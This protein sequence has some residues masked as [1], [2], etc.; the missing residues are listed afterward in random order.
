MKL[1]NKIFAGTTL[2][3]AAL[4]SQ[5][6]I[7]QPASG[8]G[9]LMVVLYTGGNSNSFVV[10]LGVTIGSFDTTINQSFNLSTSPYYATFLSNNGGVSPVGFAVLGGDQSGLNTV[11]GAKNFFFTSAAN[12]TPSAP[13][14]LTLA[15]RLGALDSFQQALNSNSGP[16]TPTF[17]G[18]HD[19]LTD[20]SSLSTSGTGPTSFSV[21]NAGVISPSGITMVAAGSQAELFKL[22]TAAGASSATT[23]LTD[24]FS[25]IEDPSN[26]GGV[27]SLNATTG[28]LDFVGAPSV[29][30][31]VPEASEWAMMLSGLGMVGLMVRRRRNNI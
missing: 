7:I 14:N 20:G 25:A 22:S 26:L 28:V 1:L 10:D 21:L 9:E 24:F 5:A 18:N 4:S 13:T 11:A 31:P 16:V 3:L 27:F 17:S 2:A 19:T 6:A 23:T 12:T 15:T 30:N 29:V 8:N